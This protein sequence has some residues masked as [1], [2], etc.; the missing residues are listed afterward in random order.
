MKAEIITIGD[1]ILIGQVVD[2]NSAWIAQQLNLIGVKV[3]Q[4][5]SAQDTSEHILESLSAAEKRADLILI[6][7]GLGP[8]KDDITK[9]VLCQYFNTQLVFNQLVYST[10]EKLFLSR[11]LAVSA[12]NRKQAE[13]PESC[14]P[15]ENAVGTASGMWFEKGGKVFVSMPGVPFEMKNMMEKQVLPKIQSFFKTPVILHKTVLTQ[16]IGESALAELIEDWESALPGFIK[17]AYLPSPGIVRLRLSA[18]GDNLLSLQD[19]IVH[20]LSKL[21]QKIDDFMFGYDEDTLQGIVGDLLSKRKASLSL[22]ESCTGGYLSHLI[23]SVPGSS[24]YYVGGLVCYSNAIKI[25]ELGVS[26]VDVEKYGSYSQQVAEQMALGIR[27]KYHTDFAVATTGIAGPG[28]GT[29]QKPVGLIWIAVAAPNGR[30]TSEKYF[31]GENRER[32]ILKAS[33]T[34]LNML[35]KEILIVCE[36]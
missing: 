10:V 22:A 15:I 30:V 31:F 19:E 4:I 20:Q 33:I 25:N 32:N 29:D 21:S 24:N 13:L 12:I 34:A 5:T 11:N 8:T 3:I 17:L 36:K 9:A 23:T 16:G 1:E 28:G 26:V 14:S 7:G 2:T 6:T 27:A 18:Y 35:R